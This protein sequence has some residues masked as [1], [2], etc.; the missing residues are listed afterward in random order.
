[1]IHYVLLLFICGYFGGFARKIID[2]H[3]KVVSKEGLIHKGYQH[4]GIETM[5]LVIIFIFQFVMTCILWYLVL[6]KI[7]NKCRR[8]KNKISSMRV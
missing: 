7:M 1:M 8:H 5:S 2:V 3:G 4:F 6:D